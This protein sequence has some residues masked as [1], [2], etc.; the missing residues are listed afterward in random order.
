MIWKITYRDKHGKHAQEY[1][2]SEN[3]NSL[4]KILRERGINA[5]K[6]D[7]AGHKEK[8]YKKWKKITAFLIGIFTAIIGLI[9]V[10]FLLEDNTPIRGIEKPLKEVPSSKKAY[11]KKEVTKVVEKKKIED[12]KK[13]RPTKVGEV[14]NG[15]VMLPS[16]RI[17]RRT[18][19]VTNSISGRPKAK[20][21]IFNRKSDNIIAGLI[22]IKPGDIILG[23]PNYNGTF[24]QDFLESLSEPITITN[25]DSPEQIELKRDVIATR[26]ELKEAYDRGEDIE[27][28]ISNTRRELQELMRVKNMYR[29]LFLEEKRNCKT[30]QDIDDLFSACNKMLEEKGITP[31]TYGPITKKNLLRSIRKESEK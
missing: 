15:Y 3:R 18:G 25:E 27:K 21:A 7:Q 19:V 20:Y 29:K 10:L 6:I 1:I 31:L 24:K 8:P 4:F 30:E 16:G 9:I 11:I 14:I 28:I 12:V 2:D 13:D 5:I 17:H 23:S 22:T 26:Q